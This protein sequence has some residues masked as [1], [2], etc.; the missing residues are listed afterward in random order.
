VTTCNSTSS[1]FPPYPSKS[2]G[3][4]IVVVPDPDALYQAFADGLRAAYGKI[5]VAG[6]PRLLRPR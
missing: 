2:Y 3:S 6:I 5:P 1:A 4:V